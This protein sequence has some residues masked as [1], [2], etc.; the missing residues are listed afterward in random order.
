MKPNKILLASFLV[1]SATAS[2]AQ[3]GVINRGTQDRAAASERHNLRAELVDAMGRSS[4][5]SAKVC[6]QLLSNP[7]VEFVGGA[8]THVLRTGLTASVEVN[9]QLGVNGARAM[10]CAAALAE[11]AEPLA[12]I[13]KRMKPT[14]DQA[15]AETQKVV[16]QRFS[17]TFTK[18]ARENRGLEKAIFKV[19]ENNAGASRPYVVANETFFR[20][21]PNPG[22]AQGGG[23][24]RNFEVVVDA[25]ENNIAS[26]A[27]PIREVIFRG[28]MAFETAAPTEINLPCGT[29]FCKHSMSLTWDNRELK[30]FKDGRPWFDAE[31]LGGAV[32]AVELT[33]E[34]TTG[35]MRKVER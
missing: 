6:R 14:R 7:G 12:D 23:D 29:G 19:S 9:Q 17:E 5:K 3:S 13:L 4:S 25:G 11:L 30:I 22:A 33:G 18:I 26:R 21:V 32:F 1:L 2:L 24:G 34:R 31:N 10:L 27:G 15:R 35:T 28:V 16:D 8:T 20:F